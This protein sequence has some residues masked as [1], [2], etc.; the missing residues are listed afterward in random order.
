MDKKA[1]KDAQERA[2]LDIEKSLNQVCETAD[3][4]FG[5]DVIQP[6]ARKVAVHVPCSMQHGSKRGNQ[7]ESVL[8]EAGFNVV[9]T[10]ERHLCC[11]SAGT[12]SILQ[13]ELSAQLRENKMQALNVESPDVIVT[14]NVGCQLHLNVDSHPVPVV[15]WLE[16]VSDSLR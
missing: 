9:S 7:L 14:A 2:R 5:H 1:D 13:P 10:K 11:G 4:H 8:R 15:H 3:R 16:L 12:F 6:D